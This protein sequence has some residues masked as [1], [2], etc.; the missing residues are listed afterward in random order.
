MAVTK[1]I[2]L[3]V[4]FLLALMSLSFF[5]TEPSYAL[6]P[7]LPSPQSQSANSSSGA[8]MPVPAIAPDPSAA[9]G[10]VLG[11]GDRVKLTVYG[12]ADI[13]G[14]Y[15]VGST[16]VVGIPLV[17]DI[18]A[19]GQTLRDFENAVARK[20]S[21]GYLK[22]PRVSAQVVNYRPFF[23][24]GEVSKPG[25]YPYVNGMTIVNAVALAGG[26]TYR[27]DKDEIT[28]TRANDPKKKDVAVDENDTVMPGDIVRVPERYF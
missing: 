1:R 16:G 11:A 17:G 13:S 14:E 22:D 6:A 2:G 5:G 3:S 18:Q 21:D 10:Y 20:L 15:E 24:L 7:S 12:E 28:V 4:F 8:T 27:A 25:S 23:I 19:A 26:Y 9:Q